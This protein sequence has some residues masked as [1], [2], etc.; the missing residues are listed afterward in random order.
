MKLKQ[1]QSKFHRLRRRLNLLTVKYLSSYSHGEIEANALS[2]DST[3]CLVS[4]FQ[5]IYLNMH[6][7][8]YLEKESYLGIYEIA[9]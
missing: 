3:H 1:F 5:K 4:V 8:L 6:I 7:N 2:N 9:S